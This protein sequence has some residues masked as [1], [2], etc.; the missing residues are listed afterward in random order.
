MPRRRCP[1]RSRALGSRSGRA[2]LPKDAQFV[3]QDGRQVTLGDYFADGK[4]V[5]LVMAYYECPMLCSLVL[6]G[7]KRA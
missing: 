2:K 3:D 4:P 5:V 6:S 1:R 7:L